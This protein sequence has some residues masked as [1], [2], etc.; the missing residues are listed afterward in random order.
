[1]LGGAAFHAA[2]KLKAKLTSIAAYQFGL[3]DDKF[4]YAAGWR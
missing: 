2:Q 1:M 3:G 4:A